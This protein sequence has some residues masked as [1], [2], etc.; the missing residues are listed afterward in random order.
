M[1]KPILSVA[2][3]IAALTL[4]LISTSCGEKEHCYTCTTTVFVNNTVHSSG[5]STFCG[6]SQ[7]VKNYETTGSVTMTQGGITTRSEV[8][9][10]R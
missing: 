6:T 4:A 1:K 3:I 7:Q 10:V 2:I 5:Q 9:C 8:K